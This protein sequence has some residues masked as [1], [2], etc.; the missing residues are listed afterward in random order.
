MIEGELGSL[1]PSG[2]RIPDAP[3]F[4]LVAAWIEAGGAST[5]PERTSIVA[6]WLESHDELLARPS[7]SA[8]MAPFVALLDT[9]TAAEHP[10]VAVWAAECSLT[11]EDASRESAVTGVRLVA[12][13]LATG[14]EIDREL[15]GSL[16]RWIGGDEEVAQ[17]FTTS[18]LA[19]QLSEEQRDAV[20]RAVLA[21]PDYGSWTGLG[22]WLELAEVTTSFSTKPDVVLGFVRAAQTLSTTHPKGAGLCLAEQAEGANIERLQTLVVLSLHEHEEATDAHEELVALLAAFPPLLAEYVETCLLDPNVPRALVDGGFVELADTD[23]YASVVALLRSSRRHPDGFLSPTMRRALILFEGVM[24]FL[25][26]RGTKGLAKAKPADIRRLWVAFDPP[27]SAEGADIFVAVLAQL[28][29]GWNPG[30]L[31][32]VE[33]EVEALTMAGRFS[34]ARNLARLYPGLKIGHDKKP[35]SEVIKGAEAGGRRRSVPQESVAYAQVASHAIEHWRARVSRGD[36]AHEDPGSRPT[37]RLTRAGNDIGRWLS[38]G[39]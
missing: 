2:G 13:T 39:E 16:V 36:D 30:W 22:R 32:P 10:A 8:G 12:M 11:G 1:E 15:A 7:R 34:E 33:C 29:K 9:A 19:G 27:G 24:E 23:D 37:G 38:R 14:T 28:R 26:K 21:E 35:A 4:G 3:V 5:N 18:L 17:A 6:S 25:E 20:L 31:T